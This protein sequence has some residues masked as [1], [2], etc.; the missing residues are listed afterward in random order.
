MKVGELREK[1]NKLK[2]EEIIKLAVEFYKR[3]PKAKK[4]DY[5]LDDLI[6]NPSQKKAKVVKS[7]TSLFE[8]QFDVDTFVEYAREQYYFAPNQYVSKRE[9]P[10]WRF[11]A[12]RFYKELTNRNLQDG[13]LQVQA[14]LLSQLYEVLCEACGIIY[15]NTDDPFRSVGVA[16]TEFYKSVLTL[17][18][19]AEGKSALVEK[20]I[21]LIIQNHLDR[22]T[23]YSGLMRQ[24]VEAINVPDLKYDAIEKTKELTTKN[25]FSPPVKNPKKRFSHTKRDYQ[26]ERRHNN[27]TELVFRLYA[28]LHEYE[29]AIKYYKKHHYQSDAEV[30]LYILISLL[31]THKKM[32]LVRRE[33]ETGIEQG[34]KPRENLMKMLDYI[35]EKNELPKF[36]NYFE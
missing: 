25:G 34:I 13:D 27:Y 18:E 20:G 16:Q 36:M 21:D 1:L 33:I 31:F 12:K 4:E 23:L 32:D 19:E 5:A 6:N 2:K 11:K 30:K 22:E 9:R 24:L 14:E 10:K 7:T 28:S 35:K 26:Q 8:L 15:F 29:E 17:M 3:V